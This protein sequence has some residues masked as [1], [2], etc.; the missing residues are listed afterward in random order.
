[1]TPDRT[2]RQKPGKPGRIVGSEGE[3]RAVSSR[4][5]ALS[6]SHDPEGQGRA[7]L[8]QQVLS[9]EN[10]VEA[11]K[12]VKANKGSA[13]A[14]GLT[15]GQTVEHLRTRCTIHSGSA[16]QRDIS[17]SVC[18]SRGDSETDWWHPGIGHSDSY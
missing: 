15:I 1:M 10:M 9:R 16:S 6:A 8:L 18:A 3:A 4:D 12:R 2:L 7:D 17:A 13:G 5:E 11:W 14:D